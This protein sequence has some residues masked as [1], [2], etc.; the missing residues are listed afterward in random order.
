VDFR[1]TQL[2]SRSVMSA[3]IIVA[4][5]A[6]PGPITKMS[7][8]PLRDEVKAMSQPSGALADCWSAAVR[9]HDIDVRIAARVLMNAICVLSGDHDGSL[10]RAASNVSR[11]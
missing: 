3:A 7:R 6:P 11:R 9:V 1:A 2:I 10:S 8:L 5:I 4:I